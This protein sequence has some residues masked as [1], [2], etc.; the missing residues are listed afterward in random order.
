MIISDAMRLIRTVQKTNGNRNTVVGISCRSRRRPDDT[1]FKQSP[2]HHHVSI[3]I[4]PV[5]MEH[6]MLG[7]IHVRSVGRTKP[8]E[9]DVL[10]ATLF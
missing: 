10:R 6:A 3:H 9:A 5:D 8:N 1:A 4:A 7:A 2:G